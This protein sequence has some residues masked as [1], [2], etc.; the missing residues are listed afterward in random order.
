MHVCAA[1]TSTHLEQFIQSHSDASSPDKLV[2]ADGRDVGAMGQDTV[3]AFTAVEVLGRWLSVVVR[4]RIVSVRGVR[5]DSPSGR[6]VQTETWST[7]G[8]ARV[9]GDLEREMG[10]GETG[11]IVG[12]GV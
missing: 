5:V 8:A 12:G 7:S 2:V 11:Y 10:V 6:G 3:S 1:K 4:V 9:A